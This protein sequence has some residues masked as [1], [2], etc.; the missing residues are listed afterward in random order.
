VLSQQAKA[1][2]VTINVNNIADAATYFAK[3]YYQAPFKFDYFSTESVWEHIGYTLLPRSVI[4]LSKWN[5]P[6]WLA[7]VTKGRGTTDSAKRKEIMGEAQR[8][9]WERGSQGIFAY[10]NTVDAYS[11][12]FAGIQPCAKGFG[13]NGALLT[14]VYTV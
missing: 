10:Y 4:N 13:L 14:D 1:A 9:F 2:G 8:M 5:D 7:T 6:R 11:T 3:Y 12:K